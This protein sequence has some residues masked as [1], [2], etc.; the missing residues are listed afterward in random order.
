MSAYI[1]THIATFIKPAKRALRDSVIE[2]NF[3]SLMASVN[4]KSLA[5]KGWSIDP[6]PTAERWFGQFDT[7]NP[8]FNFEYRVRVQVENRND[9]GVTPNARELASILR[10]LGTKSEKAAY[11]SWTLTEVDGEPYILPAPDAETSA[12]F[13]DAMIGYADVEIPEDFEEN[14]GHL[15]GLDAH[16]ARIKRS[17]IAGQMSEW[18]NRF[19]LVLQGDPGCGKSDVCQSLK[20][21]LG[22]DAVMEYDATATT[23]AGAIR[24]LSERE[25]LPR[26]LIVEEIEKADSAAL[27]FLLGVMDLRGEI[28]K[29]TFKGKIE[30]E[31]K[32]LVIATV[33]NVAMF[34]GIAAGALASR[35][36]NKVH[37]KR[38][39]RDM[40]SMILTREVAKVEGDARWITPTLDYC[41][42]RNITDPRQVIALCLCG[43]DGWLTG[44]YAKELEET[45]EEVV[46]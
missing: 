27:A 6:D 17:I 34:E 33:N 16:V 3:T 2:G 5:Q 30:R 7:P 4:N 11:G 36:A 9:K 44:E 12:S 1:E 40:L 21:A 28:R 24:D 37:F 14:F 23:G 39:S 20:R 41:D 13:T 35:F 26:V 32:L 25:I 43:M 10:E 19:H 8:N 45:A 22:N 31:T 38:P 29:T 15:F 18:K 42:A 46:N